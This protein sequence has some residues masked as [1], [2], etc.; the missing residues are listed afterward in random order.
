MEKYCHF[1]AIYTLLPTSIFFR[2]ANLLFLSLQKCLFFV[3]PSSLSLLNPWPA[4][5][6]ATSGADWPK[7][8]EGGGREYV[9]LSLRW[10]VLSWGSVRGEGLSSPL[11][12][13]CLGL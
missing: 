10:G 3:S 9:D 8:G 5:S 4:S 7:E 6:L 12:T 11:F 2:M 1:I 13:V